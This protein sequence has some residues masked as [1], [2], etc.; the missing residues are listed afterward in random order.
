MFSLCKYALFV[1]FVFFG[2]CSFSLTVGIFVHGY[3]HHYT[4]AADLPRRCAR[5]EGNIRPNVVARCF[6]YL[7]QSN[8]ILNNYKLSLRRAQTYFRPICWKPHSL[9][10][11]AVAR[12]SVFQTY[13]CVLTA[14]PISCVLIE[15]CKKRQN[16][17][18]QE[19]KREK[20]KRET[21][22]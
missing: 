16:K 21:K 7:K 22:H 12:Y 14:N 20:E 5:R 15:N 9:D 11:L 6:L 13:G 4:H 1:L 8:V 2:L 18:V 17:N 3:Y 10:T 19:R